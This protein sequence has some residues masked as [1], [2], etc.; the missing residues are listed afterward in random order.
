MKNNPYSLFYK[1]NFVL[2]LHLNPN[3]NKILKFILLTIVELLGHSLLIIK[4][5]S[6]PSQI[7]NFV[8]FIFVQS[9]HIRLTS[10]FKISN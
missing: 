8:E 9:A 5:L 1:L 3:F 10:V 6:N 2:E 7:F 4:L